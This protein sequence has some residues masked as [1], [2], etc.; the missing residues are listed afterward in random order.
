[1]EWTFAKD[2]KGHKADH[3]IRLRRC[4]SINNS[5]PYKTNMLMQKTSHCIK[6]ENHE[7]TSKSS[8]FSYNLQGKK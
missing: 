4:V 6:Q 1:M 7:P 2:K 8:N 5:F 3:R